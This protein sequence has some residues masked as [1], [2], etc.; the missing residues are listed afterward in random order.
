VLVR[1]QDEI[2]FISTL[3]RT[4]GTHEIAAQRDIAITLIQGLAPSHE[5]VSGE[6]TFSLLIL[7]FVS[8]ALQ[9]LFLMRYQSMQRVRQIAAIEKQRGSN[10]VRP[11]ER[12]AL[13]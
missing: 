6:W 4:Y 7:L 3:L 13:R 1:T 5:S 9:S 10:Y 8:S 2:R 12:I 11:V